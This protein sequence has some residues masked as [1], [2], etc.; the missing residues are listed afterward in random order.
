MSGNGPGGG[1]RRGQPEARQGRPI[2]NKRE[3]RDRD[4]KWLC[5]RYSLGTCEEGEKS[6][7]THN[8][9][10]LLHKVQEPIP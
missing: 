4:G 7:C 5:V 2:Y 6:S 8:G 3:A 1:A 9:Q 10:T